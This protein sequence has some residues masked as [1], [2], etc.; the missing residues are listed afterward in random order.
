MNAMSSQNI[1]R[2]RTNIAYVFR[3]FNDF[4]YTGIKTTF[5]VNG[6]HKEYSKYMCKHMFL[7]IFIMG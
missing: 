6:P 5:K 2:N 4:F 7:H 1:A 3:K